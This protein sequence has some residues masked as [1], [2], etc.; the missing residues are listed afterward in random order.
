M[1]D[2]AGGAATLNVTTQAE[3]GWDASSAV[4]WISGLSPASGQGTGRVDFR[5]A[6]ND[7]SAA[8]DGDIL[9]N[10]TAV[11]VS[12]R[13]ACRFALTPASQTIGSEGGAGN[14]RIATASGCAWT[15][16]SHASW[17]VL[18]SGS[19]G[20]GDGAI[21]FSVAA[22]D[23]ASRTG[24]L[25]IA[26]QEFLL[27]QAGASSPSPSPSPPPAPPSSCTYSI[28]PMSQ[29]VLA[30]GGVGTVNVSTARTCAWTA[31][32]NAS[33]LTVTAG[34][35]GSGN[36][37]VAFAA[38]VNAGAARTGT[39][40]IANQTFTVTQAAVIAV[41][42][43]YSISPNNQD[44]SAAG[45]SAS[46]SVSTTSACA[47]TASS[48]T[49]WITI[50]SGSSGTG[51]GTVTFSVARNDGKKRNGSLTV[52]GRNARVEQDDD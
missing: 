13:A 28:S 16:G 48:N 8:R 22:N 20:V 17:I 11:R 52:A 9:V 32:S 34:A 49:A 40:T 43:E 19:S 7:G 38:A 3:C 4:A 45:G 41:P 42:C 2:A 29:S 18:T 25:T 1:L 36:G 12:Q 15:A 51:N 50:T 14:V 21:A 44:V 26:G 24:T 39:I 47:W 30:V 5:V 10:G 27:T 37:S 33:W 31:A 46:V 6:A 35:T 23:G